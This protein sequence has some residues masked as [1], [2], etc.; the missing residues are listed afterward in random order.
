MPARLMA[1]KPV[2]GRA[3][4]VRIEVDR[5]VDK[6]ANHQVLNLRPILRHVSV[7]HRLNRIWPDK[8]QVEKKR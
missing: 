8:R 5:V 6:V 7:H 3:V 1:L 2:E 4:V